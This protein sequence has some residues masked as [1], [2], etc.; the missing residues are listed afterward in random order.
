LDCLASLDYALN[1]GKR[2]AEVVEKNV[3]DP[4]TVAVCVQII[5]AVFFLLHK[6]HIRMFCGGHVCSLQSVNC[7]NLW[8][9]CGLTR[10]AVTEEE[11]DRRI[12]EITIWQNCP[13]LV[14][15]IATGDPAVSL[16]P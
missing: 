4:L 14:M 9:I 11:Q 6:Q 1:Y 10:D 13:R 12:R 2:I 8:K 15:T 16:E 3:L 7:C 5:L